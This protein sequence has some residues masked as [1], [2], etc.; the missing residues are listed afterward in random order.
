MPSEAVAEDK[1]G[2]V[3]LAVLAAS[4]VVPVVE[5]LVAALVAVALVAQADS[6][7]EKGFGVIP[8][9]FLLSLP[10]DL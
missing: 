5:A 4:V 10:Q 8:K 9:P 2:L 6:K 3:D 7:Q 1:V